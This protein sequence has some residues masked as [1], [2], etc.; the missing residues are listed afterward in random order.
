M[1][2][3]KSTEKVE[4]KPGVYVH[5]E[6]GKSVV[7]EDAHGFGHQI[8]DAFIQ[9]GYVRQEETKVETKVEPKTA[10]EVKK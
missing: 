10:P 4:N 9:T 3:E 2:A 1:A 5:R 8:A 6:S 7:I